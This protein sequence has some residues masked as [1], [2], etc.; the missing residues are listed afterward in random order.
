[1]AEAEIRIIKLPEDSNPSGD[2]F[3]V[4]DGAT[5]RRSRIKDAVKKGVP[6]ATEAEVRAGADIDKAVNPL[7][8]KQSID[9]AAGSVVQPYSP[10]LAT[11][12]GITP[13]G[14]G[15]EM[16]ALA[17]QPHWMLDL[18]PGAQLFLGN[19]QGAAWD[20]LAN[21][22]VVV[23]GT[24]PASGTLL[25][26]LDFDRDSKQYKLSEDGLFTAAAADDPIMP[27]RVPADGTPTGIYIGEYKQPLLYY[28]DDLT[29]SSWTLENGAT[30]EFDP[31]VVNPAGGNG[32][33]KLSDTTPGSFGALST[34]VL[35]AVSDGDWVTHY[36]FAKAGTS[37]RVQIKP[38]FSGGSPSYTADSI[39]DL[40]T[41]TVLRSVNC[42]AGMIAFP[43]G[44]WL[45]K[46]AV[47]NNSAGNSTVT[48]RMVPDIAAVE[49]TGYIW[50]WDPNIILDRRWTGHRAPEDQPVRAALTGS[51]WNTL[52]GDA[53]PGV[54]GASVN[55]AQSINFTTG[56]TLTSLTST[57]Q[58]GT[59]VGGRDMYR[60]TDTSAA[61]FGFAQ[62]AAGSAAGASDYLYF[63]C[64]IN[65]T[66]YTGKQAEFRHNVTGGPGLSIRV[67]VDIKAR[68]VL[69]IPAGFDASGTLWCEVVPTDDPDV[70]LWIVG[71][72]NNGSTT[73][74]FTFYP[75][76]AATSGVGYADVGDPCII[77]SASD[78]KWS[79]SAVEAIEGDQLTIPAADMPWT[80][81][82]GTVAV[83]FGDVPAMLPG[84]SKA[85]T[86]FQ[87][88]SGAGN[89]RIL[90]RLQYLTDSTFAAVAQ[91]IGN[92]GA[93]L[94]LV[95]NDIP[96]TAA[97]WWLSWNSHGAEM[98][99]DDA[100][101]ASTDDATVR[102]SGMT[103]F[104]IASHHGGGGQPCAVFKRGFYRPIRMIASSIASAGNYD[105]PLT[106]ATPT[107]FSDADT[108]AQTAL[109]L[110][111]ASELDA[112]TRTGLVDLSV[113]TA[114]Y[115]IF[116]G[117]MSQS[118]LRAAKTATPPYTDWQWRADGRTGWMT[119]LMLGGSVR[120]ANGTGTTFTPVA[121]FDGIPGG[122]PGLNPLVATA[123]G[124]G[125]VLNQT[126]LE[127]G[128]STYS[129]SYSGESPVVAMV[130]EFT[131][132][133]NET[134]G[135]VGPN[136]D[137]V[138]IGG[139][140]GSSADT[141]FN[142][143]A[144]DDAAWD[145]DVGARMLDWLD[146]V[147][148]EI[149]AATAI[150]AVNVVHWGEAGYSRN[151]SK[152]DFLYGKDYAGQTYAGIGLY[153]ALD[154]THSLALT[155]NP[156]QVGVP[157]TVAS[158]PSMKWT[159]DSLSIAEAYTEAEEERDDLVVA[160]VSA[161]AQPG[162]E[163]NEHPS[164]LLGSA[165]LGL[166]SARAA[167]KVLVSGE[168]YYI[169]KPLALWQAGRH[170][171][172]AMISQYAMQFKQWFTAYNP[173]ELGW[174]DNYGF[175]IKYGAGTYRIASLPTVL[176]GGR[177]I[178]IELTST[179]SGLV[180]LT[181]MPL[182]GAGGHSNLFDSAPP[183]AA[184]EC[185]HLSYDDVSRSIAA[186]NG[187]PLPGH[188]MARPF[189]ITAEEWEG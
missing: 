9:E 3:V 10:N 67:S 89:G 68:K 150:Y 91:F 124:G 88:D 4:I 173:S 112:R 188:R 38:V 74:R 111:A 155:V 23:G 40:E 172:L 60:L 64:F 39:F 56:W 42:M 45:C 125:N 25:S 44:I 129:S 178:D 144:G 82:S 63:G 22:A 28:S 30:V 94:S 164:A 2:D 151:F 139:V 47:K 41:G 104:R 98:G 108:T 137:N 36:A 32:M 187:A 59:G 122:T 17:H 33:W 69:S 1:M 49:N 21:D 181:H 168:N 52:A 135:I 90:M 189:V 121:D 15:L 185:R 92:D 78:N 177:V 93:T 184:W 99:R 43:G 87:I 54:F 161:V 143:V 62:G 163:D 141:D 162:A 20:A 176:E 148:A 12:A 105:V 103:T 186:L 11:I 80:S 27:A 167:H 86:L 72:R 180:T 50:I 179:P 154:A 31:T 100:V 55:K 110:A 29:H 102:P 107:S 127:A 126:E 37:N 138:V 26:I 70:D 77:Y 123:D 114:D 156:A 116:N 65:R 84:V 159:K 35:N 14:W 34:N 66:T 75:D 145:G 140:S 6:Y 131:R 130:A 73:P 51:K 13:G 71:F 83:D 158:I 5:T 8:V 175:L 136:T 119:A 147:V 157:L 182:T 134:K 97:R 18:F 133:R 115:L 169:P 165:L 120:P 95:A 81:L 101:M 53:T 76:F 58:A 146:Q 142:E 171:R 61:A 183:F 113:S 132:L 118:V 152:N 117:C 79:R 106:P 109:A 48:W 85:V 170:L 166:H 7:G 24:A 46:T 149:G 160:S 57:L 19:Q 128:Y 153:A 96:I 16:L 174:V